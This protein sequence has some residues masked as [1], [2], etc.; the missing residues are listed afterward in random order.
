M[1]YSAKVNIEDLSR[2]SIKKKMK[3]DDDIVLPRFVA[4]KEAV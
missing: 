3:R 4:T 1:F 2:K